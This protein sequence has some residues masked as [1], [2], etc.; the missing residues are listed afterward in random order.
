MLPVVCG[1]YSL[2]VNPPAIQ[3]HFKLS[4]PLLPPPHAEFAL[5]RYNIAPTQ[6]VLIVRPDAAGARVGAWTR[7]GLVPPNAK[8]LSGGARMIN[9]RAETIFDKPVFKMAAQLRRCLVPSDGF[10]EWRSVG[11]KKQPYRMMLKD[12]GLFGMAGVWS[13]WRAEDGCVVDTCSVLTCAPNELA[14]RFHDRMPVILRP[15][16]WDLWLDRTIKDRAPLEHLL[17]PYANEE[18]AAVPVSRNVN[19]VRRDDPTCVEEVEPPAS[20]PKQLGFS[21]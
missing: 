1:R 9:A 4:Q 8:D 5:P 21:F 19:D 12:G 7:W 17:V 16:S 20:P 13:R 10:F 6:D 18:M 2:S 11:R 14:G 3:L 15:E